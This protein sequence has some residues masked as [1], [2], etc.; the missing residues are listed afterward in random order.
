V[1]SALCLGPGGRIRAWLASIVV[2]AGLSCLVAARADA[3]PANFWGVVP[4]GELSPE[5]FERLKRGGVDSVRIGIDWA[6][7]QPS[8]GTAPNWSGIDQVVGQAASAGLEVLPFVT[9]A[10]QWAVRSVVVNAASHSF[11]PLNLPV[12]TA[13]QR[14]GWQALLG[15]AVR[16]YGPSG[17]FWNQNPAIPQRPIRVWQ[18]WNEENFKYFVA[19]PNPVEYGKLVK[20]SSTAIKAVDPGAKIILGG[21]FARPKEAEYKRKPPS[22]YFATDFLDRMYAKTPGVKSKFQGVALHPYTYDYHQLTPDIEALRTVLKR[23]HDA[24]K[25][26]WITELGWSSGRPKASNGFNQFEKGP[27]GQA[28]QLKGAFKLIVGKQAKWRLRQLFWFSVGD[29]PGACNFCDGSG[30]FG[31]G[32]VAKPSWNAYV[33]FAGGRAT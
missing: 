7:V 3:V 27:G 4:Q 25:G 22:A 18:I 9:G 12:R 5:Q 13:A 15:E 21:M 17:T 30:L 2:V 33:R 29:A 19:H 28:A 32:F 11:A 24:A 26:L 31:P 16:R 10:P 23:H 14:E 6:T 20:L 8:P 1:A